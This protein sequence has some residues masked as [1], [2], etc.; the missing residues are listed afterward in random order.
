MEFGQVVT[1][2]GKK[3][4]KRQKKKGNELVIERSP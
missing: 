3:T 4:K 1:S 2:E